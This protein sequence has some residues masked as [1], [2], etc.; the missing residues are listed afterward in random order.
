M[1]AGFQGAVA[2]LTPPTFFAFRLNSFSLSIFIQIFTAKAH[3][4]L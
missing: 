1:E 4:G 3:K 2:A